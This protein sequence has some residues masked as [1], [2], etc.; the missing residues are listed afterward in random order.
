MC[1]S[2]PALSRKEIILLLYS[3]TRRYIYNIE[4]QFFGGGVVLPQKFVFLEYTVGI[5]YSIRKPYS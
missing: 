2:Q 1:I 5:I 3:I 4:Y